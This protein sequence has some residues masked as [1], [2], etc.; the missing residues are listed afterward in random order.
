MHFPNH[1]TSSNQLPLL[2]QHSEAAFSAVM[3]TAGILD[4]TLC[5][6]KSGP[7]VD[8]LA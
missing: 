4:K 6:E 7:T 8:A 1:A 5:T 3:A 2:A